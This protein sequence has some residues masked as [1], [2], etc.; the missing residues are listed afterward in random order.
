MKK[1]IT[2]LALAAV[3]GISSIGVANAGPREDLLA[4]FANEAGMAVSDFSAERGK[5]IYYGDW[6]GQQGPDGKSETPKCT[7]C[8]GDT[9]Q[10]GGQTRAGKPIDP[11]AVSSTPDRFTDPTKVAKWFR[12]NCKGVIGREC[13]P[14]EKG[15][16]ITFLMSQ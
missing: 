11:M 6:T 3:I 8:H 10:Q 13:T 9:P 12:R 7:S 4:K 16:F 2:T 15:D 1:S 5:E 14:Q